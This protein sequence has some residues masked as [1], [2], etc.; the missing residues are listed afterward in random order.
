MGEGPHLFPDQLCEFAVPVW[1]CVGI[2]TL[3]LWT[4]W[5]DLSVSRFQRWGVGPRQRNIFNNIITAS[6]I[7]GWNRKWIV[8]VHKVPLGLNSWWGWSCVY[9]S[10]TRTEGSVYGQIDLGFLIN[11]LIQLILKVLLRVERSRK[12]KPPFSEELI[13]SD[14]LIWCILF[15]HTKFRRTLSTAAV[16]C[17]FTS[18]DVAVSVSGISPLFWIRRDGSLCSHDWHPSV[19][20]LCFCWGW[21]P[22][23]WAT[24]FQGCWKQT[25]D[26]S[27]WVEAVHLF[28]FVRLSKI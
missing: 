5:T 19:C 2:Q 18:R 10:Q 15:L 25:Q 28:K 13:R 12:W 17:L 8:A 27:F 21:F 16:V 22:N 1:D 14:S 24:L 4:Y 20:C 9:R 7:F 26:Y 3:S 11:R 6:N 23:R